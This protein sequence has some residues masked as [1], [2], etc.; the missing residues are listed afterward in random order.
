MKY[1]HIYRVCNYF[2]L[3]IAELFAAYYLISFVPLSAKDYRIPF[4]R[5]FYRKFYCVRSVR[6]DGARNIF[7]ADPGQNILWEPHTLED[8]VMDG[9]LGKLTAE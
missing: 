9:I 2:T 1:K 5:V 7:L 3:I 4:A 8:A 6:Y